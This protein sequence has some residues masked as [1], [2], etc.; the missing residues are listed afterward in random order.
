MPQFDPAI[1]SPLLVWLVLTFVAL[2]FLMSKF[3]LPKV[4]TIIDQ[5]AER[6]EGNLAK[7]EQLKSEAAAVLAAYEKGIADAKAQ[8]QAELAKAA[9]EIAAETARREADFGKRLAEQT[10]TAET[11]IKAAQA[12]AMAQVKAIASDLAAGI[13]TKL[14]GTSVD[15]ASASAAV[16]AVIKERA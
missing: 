4:A 8:A 10:K 3:A 1:F 13:S 16:E 15:Q 9:A 14:T 2:Y 7:A 11:R 12:D 6:I 5:R